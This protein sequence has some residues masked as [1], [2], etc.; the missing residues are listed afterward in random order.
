MEKALLIHFI[1][2]WLLVS[3]SFQ[4]GGAAWK[5]SF[6]NNCRNRLLIDVLETTGRDLYP[7]VFFAKND[8]FC[9]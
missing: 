8:S 3:Q 7:A 1:Q 5:P 2:L 4:A 9:L 6:Y